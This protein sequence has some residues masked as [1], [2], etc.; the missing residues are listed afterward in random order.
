[1]MST[2]EHHFIFP[3]VIDEVGIHYNSYSLE[4]VTG[5]HMPCHRMESSVITMKMRSLG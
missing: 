1:M 4:I 3:S 5:H 2:R